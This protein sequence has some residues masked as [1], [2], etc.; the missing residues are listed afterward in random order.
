MDNIR[1]AL[2]DN[3]RHTVNTDNAHYFINEQYTPIN[4]PLVFIKKNL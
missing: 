4:V 2:E 3:G 1:R